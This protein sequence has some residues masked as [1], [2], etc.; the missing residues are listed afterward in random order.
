MQSYL[1]VRA[2]NIV[3]ALSSPQ[4]PLPQ[5]MYIP[6]ISF[7]VY[8]LH[9]FSTDPEFAHLIEYR[10]RRVKTFGV[11]SDIYDGEEYVKHSELF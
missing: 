5:S 1:L 4:T 6:P 7:L 10:F 9:C 3:A 11:L 8:T 2:H